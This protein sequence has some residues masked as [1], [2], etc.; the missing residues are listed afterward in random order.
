[1]R[2]QNKQKIHINLTSHFHLHQQVSKYLRQ[3]IKLSTQLDLEI[4]ITK[5]HFIVTNIPDYILPYLIFVIKTLIIKCGYFIVSILIL[6]SFIKIRNL[7][8]INLT[9]DFSF[10]NEYFFLKLNLKLFQK[11]K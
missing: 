9:Y 11:R 6:R 10:F 4:I 5:I 2:V 3:P 1:M 7:M 8:V